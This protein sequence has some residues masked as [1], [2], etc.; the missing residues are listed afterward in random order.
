MTIAEMLEEAVA[1]HFT[2]KNGLFKALKQG[3]GPEWSVW[4]LSRHPDRIA[5]N[6]TREEAIACAYKES[7]R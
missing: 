7:K 5:H 6:V 4:A 1:V 2:G 3:G